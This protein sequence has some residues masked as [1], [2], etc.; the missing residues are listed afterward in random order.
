MNIFN[1]IEANL[2]AFSDMIIPEIFI[3]L[4]TDENGLLGRDAKERLEKYGLNE[5][6]YEKPPS[7]ATLLW[8]SYINPFN[9]LVSVLGFIYFFLDDIPGTIII[10]TMVAISVIIRFIQEFRSHIAAEKLKAMVSTNATVIRRG[11][12]QSPPLKIEIPI[13]G[14][15]PR[16]HHFSFSR[17]YGAR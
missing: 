17:R 15:S 10:A 9:I 7:F 14:F 8:R 4:N 12:I 16:R 3:D 2:P 11:D 6:S 1:N 5:I 13:K